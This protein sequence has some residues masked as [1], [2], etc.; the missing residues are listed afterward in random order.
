MRHLFKA[1]CS[2][3]TS[4]AEI[5][6][7]MLEFY[8]NLMGKPT[9]NLNNSVIIAIRDGKQLTME[10]KIYLVSLGVD[11]FEEYRRFEGP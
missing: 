1:D 8:G 2:I 9:H 4:Q 5:K 6:R 3:L 10:E 7:E 11:G